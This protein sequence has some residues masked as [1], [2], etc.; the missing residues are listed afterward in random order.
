MDLLNAWLD[1]V[2][3]VLVEPTHPGNVGAC[4]RAM[5]AMGLSRLAIADAD[6]GLTRDP[7]AIAMASGAD[8]VLEAV[9]FGTL[10]DLLGPTVLRLALTARPREFEPPRRTLTEAMRECADQLIGGPSDEI[11]LVFGPERSGLSNEHVLMCS[12]V[13]GLDVNPAF[14]SLN[15]S[16]AVQVVSFALR[17]ALRLAE[18]TAEP[19][20]TTGGAGRPTAVP[21]RSEAVEGLHQ[22]L[23]RVALDSEALDPSHPGRMEERLRRLW[24]RSG[25]LEDEVQMLRG[26]LSEVERQ[27]SRKA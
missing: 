11:A 6:R 1:R 5:L 19:T 16:Q 20:V 24:A 13:C 14:S 21:A 23:L 26:I 27:L 8:S 10:P 9:R 25:L 12:R 18:G 22:H 3:V 17:A 7:Q 4:A 15:L 2:T